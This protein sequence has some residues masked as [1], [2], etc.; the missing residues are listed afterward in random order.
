MALHEFWLYPIFNNGDVYRA[1]LFKEPD[2]LFDT[3][4]GLQYH[5]CGETP[6]MTSGRTLIAYWKED[7]PYFYNFC[8]WGKTGKRGYFLTNRIARQIHDGIRFITP[9]IGIYLINP[10]DD[11]EHWKEIRRILLRFL[12]KDVVDTIIQSYLHKEV[13]FGN[14]DKHNV[15]VDGKYLAKSPLW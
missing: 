7:Y 8:R 14:L 2:C 6:V 9:H 13:Y 3:K 15:L 10:Y 12:P 4:S 1:F 11:M 5:N